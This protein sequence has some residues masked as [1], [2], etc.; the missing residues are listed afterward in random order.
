MTYDAAPDSL[1][2]RRRRRHPRLRHGHPRHLRSSAATFSSRRASAST[3]GDDARC[4]RRRRLPA[5]SARAAS[6]MPG[7]GHPLHKPV[8]P[9]AERILALAD[10]REIAGRYIDL[11]RRF[12]PAVAKAWGRA[13]A[14]ERLDADRRLPARPRFSGDDDQGDPAPRPHR[15]PPRP[16]RRGAGAADRLPDGV[17]RPRKRSPTT[18]ARRAERR[19]VRARGR[20]AALAE[21]QAARRRRLYRDQIAYL[22]ARSRFYRGKLAA[23]GF[24]VGRRGRRAR[25]DRPRCPSPRR[26]NCAPR[27]AR[28]IRSAPISPS[29]MNEARPHLLDQ[30]HHRHAELHPADRRR[31][32]QL[33][34]HLGAHLRRLG[35]R[36][37]A[38][39]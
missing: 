1:Q 16:S 12:A 32:R 22:F 23:A 30:R 13:A 8:D 19:H 21:Q 11:A 34:A 18:A 29:P 31:P 36:A 20:D 37:A 17:A 33:D 35:P 10:D 4:R 5:R 9:R 38:S 26:T 28:P 39:G 27:A 2:A 24:A 25:R 7:F 14:D 6:K 3:A 15:R